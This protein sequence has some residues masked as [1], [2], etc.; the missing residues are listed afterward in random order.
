MECSNFRQR[1]L[2]M[3][4]YMKIS[5]IEEINS[6]KGCMW[7]KYEYILHYMFIVHSCPPLSLCLW[8]YS[9][10]DFITI[11]KVSSQSDIVWPQ[12]TA[13]LLFIFIL[14]YIFHVE[15]DNKIKSSERLLKL[16]RYKTQDIS[17]NI[18]LHR[19]RN[20]FGHNFKLIRRNVWKCKPTY[21]NWHRSEEELINE[22]L[23]WIIRIE[24]SAC[25]QIGQ[26]WKWN[27]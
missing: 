13:T 14:Y 10:L 20:F 27:F 7:E 18:E 5:C 3:K 11:F 19:V 8:I 16:K 9:R 21:K 15:A 26:N 12:M 24:N 22:I 17:W 25:E 23:N 1:V 4:M 2:Q 6:L